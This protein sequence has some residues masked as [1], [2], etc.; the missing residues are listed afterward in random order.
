[1]S[2]P[3]VRVHSAPCLVLL[4][5]LC[6]IWGLAAVPKAHA[7]EPA[8]AGENPVSRRELIEQ[9]ERLTREIAKLR[10]EFEALREDHAA[11][12]EQ[13]RGLLPLGNRITGYLDFG[14]FYVGGNGTALRNDIGH[15]H[16][17]EY[18]GK[19]P[20]SWV[21]MGDPLATAINSR[22]DP[23]NTG[24]SRSITFNPIKSE[25]KPSFIL[26]NVNLALFTG[27]TENLQVN[28]LIDFVP[29]GRN[30]SNPDGLFLGDYIDVKLAYAEYSVPVQSFRLS[31]YAGKFDS[32]LGYEY[33]IQEAPDR[34]TVTPSLICRYTCGRP[35]GLKARLGLFDNRLT[36]NAALTNGSN[37]IEQFPF[38]DETDSNYFQTGSGRIAY[39]LPLGAGLEI[40]LSGA[41]GV[42]DQQ[43]DKDVLQWHY[44]FDLHLELRGLVVQ[45]E[46]VQGRASGKS[47]APEVR[48]DEA[49]CL[50]Y[51]GAYGL[52]AY[53]AT[54]W[55]M[56]YA[57]VDW[58]EALHES[59][60][61]FVY[62]SDAVRVTGGLRSEIG[63]Y[64]ILK[65][66][67]THVREIGRLIEFPDDVVTSSLVIKY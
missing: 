29:R 44:G 67:Y 25:G 66:E 22:G 50:E 54:N 42:Q 46:F 26:N 59:G 9:N 51:K 56:P 32:V 6:T 28:A 8:P 18:Q 38:Y 58:R 60:A 65:A 45:A 41:V 23:A 21:F 2:G 14:F 34:I 53:R 27:L 47:S 19:V 15:Q 12:S 36:L 7:D 61:S 1:M 24:E 52:I 62:I 35:V 5:L 33:R 48:C 37:F 43:A 20:D 40:G 63:R 31:L 64:V 57:R 39:K 30:V 3:S 55:L 4:F 10:Q 13:V 49:Q 11:T 16:F 17:P